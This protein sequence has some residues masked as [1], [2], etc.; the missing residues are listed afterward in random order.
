MKLNSL[1]SKQM[2][3]DTYVYHINSIVNHEKIWCDPIWYNSNL[4]DWVILSSLGLSL[5]DAIPLKIEQ[6]SL[7]LVFWQNFKKKF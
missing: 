6:I 3:F 7:V 2:Q 5:N 4:Y 1:K